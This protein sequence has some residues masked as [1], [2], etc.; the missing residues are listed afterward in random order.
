M[1][2]G[3]LDVRKDARADHERQREHLHEQQPRVQRVRRPRA[4]QRHLHVGHRAPRRGR[5]DAPRERE[6]RPREREGRHRP[7]HRLQQPSR[8]F[9]RLCAP[10]HVQHARAP[11]QQRVPRLLHPVRHHCSQCLCVKGKSGKKKTWFSREAQ[12]EGFLFFPCTLCTWVHLSVCAR[13][14]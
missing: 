10:Y 1:D 4:A 9:E 8:P 12:V 14:L 3:A 6:R 11:L 13:E 7:P 5:R 2:H